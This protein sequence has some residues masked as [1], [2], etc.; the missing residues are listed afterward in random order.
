MKRKPPNVVY[1]FEP[2]E[3]KT[4][5]LDGCA[6]GKRWVFRLRPQSGD[7]PWY[8]RGVVDEAGVKAALSARQFAKFRRGVTVF[9][10]ERTRAM[11]YEAVKERSRPRRR[12][13]T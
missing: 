7:E 1:W 3:G 11:K 6:F 8:W 2:L 13:V 4:S 5:K 12:P 9:V 10:N